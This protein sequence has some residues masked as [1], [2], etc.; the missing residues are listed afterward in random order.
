MGKTHSFRSAESQRYSSSYS[1]NCG[2]SPRMEPKVKVKVKSLSGVG[3]FATPWTEC[4][5]PGSSVHGI[6]QARILEWVAITFS[7]SV[8]KVT[9]TWDIYQDDFIPPQKER[10]ELLLDPARGVLQLLKS[11][12]LC[13]H[14]RYEKQSKPGV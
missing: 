10:L 2:E 13:F 12:H 4:S 14:W 11:K 1:G 7:N 5:P 8:V 9:G 3:L 6:L